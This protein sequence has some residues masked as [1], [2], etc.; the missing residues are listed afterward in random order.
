METEAL[1]NEESQLFTLQYSIGGMSGA[2]A[3][4]H[5][6]AW[7]D[8]TPRARELLWAVTSTIANTPGDSFTSTINV[9]PPLATA[10]NEI[11]SLEKFLSKRAQRTLPFEEFSVLSPSG[12]DS[13]AR[14][15]LPGLV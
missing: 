15:Q 2:A 11:H 10:F 7:I 3:Y 12:L 14:L 5:F 4:P 8:T 9:P 13:A 1:M 6:F